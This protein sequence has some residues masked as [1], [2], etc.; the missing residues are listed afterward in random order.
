MVDFE[1]KEYIFK[2]PVAEKI[3]R[4][5]HLKDIS[6]KLFK[7][8]KYYKAE[9]MYKRMDQYFK[10]KDFKGNFCK[11]DDTTT[12]YRDGMVHLENFQLTNSS[13]L[14]VVS[15]KREHYDECIK[16]CD[17]AID[18][19]HKHVKAIFLKG[20]AYIGKQ[21]YLKAIEAFKD[22]LEFDPDNTDAPKEIQRAQ[23]MQKKYDEKSTAM[24][25][26]MF[27]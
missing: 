6:T 1:Q 10:A 7:A 5:N 2:L 3:E 14:A 4:L 21:D 19:D 27:A 11:E 12:D 16:F 23:V 18:V 15:L 9:K 22:V 26:K 17:E 24:A 8:Q 13:N 20:K 25:K